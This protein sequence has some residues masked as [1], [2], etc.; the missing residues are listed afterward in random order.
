MS[1][2]PKEEVDEK[3]AKNSQ[4]NQKGEENDKNNEAYFLILIPSEEKIDFQGLSYKTKNMIDPSIIFKDRVEKDDKTYL[5]EIVFKFKKKK[6]KKEKAGNENESSKSTKYAITFFE[7][8]HIY[9]ITFAS[10]NDCFIY[11]P[12]LDIG[13]KFLQDIP[14]EPIQQNIV[15]LYIKL[16]IFIKALKKTKEINQKEE[17]LYED[18]IDLYEQK[19]Q[20]SLLI[21]LFLK[22]Y[23]KNKELCKQLI[24][25]FYRINDEENNDK[26]DDL[27]NHLKSF[28]DILSNARDI[29]DENNYNPIHFYG[30]LFCYLH[31]YDENNFPKKIEEFSEGNSKT[32]YEI[33]IHYYSHFINPLK[34]SQKFFKGFIGYA[35]KEN[36][37][38]KQFERI[39]NY[40]EDIETYLFI[41]DSNKKEIFKKYKELR[42]KP[43]EMD[44]SLKLL[45]HKDDKTKKTITNEKHNNESESSDEDNEKG[46]EYANNIEN[47]CHVII[48]L[49]ESIIKF[50]EE[51]KTLVIYMRSTFWI[52]LLDQ[53]KFPDWENISNCHNLRELYKK[54]TNLVN[55][56]Y[57]ENDIKNDVNTFFDRDQFAFMLNNLIKEFLDKNQ[58]S[59]TNAE[60]LGCVRNFNPY[61]SIADEKDKNK[62]KNNR[63]TY[64][65][66]YVNFSKITH[67]F[68]KAFHIFNFETMFEENISEYI[69]KITG[70]IK[71]IK[72]FGNIIKLI[73]EKRMKEDNQKDYYRIL[74]EKYRSVIKGNIKLIKD[75]KELKNGIK[76]IAE[77]V[78]K[79]FLFYGKND[80]LKDEIGSLED[81]IKSLIYLELIT[82]YNKEEYKDQKE[83]I[84]DIY[85][86][87]D[88]ISKKEGRDNIIKLVKNLKDNDRNIFIYEKL[89]KAC[90]FTTDEFFSNNEN[91]K[92]KTLCLL[93]E[94][95]NKESKD[96]KV[97]ELN[98]IEQGEKGNK[99]AKGLE[100]VLDKV[101]KEL[102][103]GRITKR[104]LERFLNIKKVYIN[105]TNETKKEKE[106]KNVSV[107]KNDESDKYAKEKLCLIALTLKDYVAENKYIEYKKIIDNINETIAKLITTKDSLMIFHRNKYID[108]IKKLAKILIEIEN[109]PIAYL[110]N[111]ETS[112]SVDD[113]INTH[114]DLCDQI[115]EVKDFLLFK[116]IFEDT[117][118]KDQEDRFSKAYNKL[119][120]LKI[121]FKE[122]PNNI[123]VIF[124]DKDFVNIFKEIKEELGRKDEIKS[125]EFLEQMKNNFDIT[126]ENAIK[127]LKML[128][129]SKKYEMIVKSIDYFFHYFLNKDLKLNEKKK[130]L[131][132]QPLIILKSELAELEKKDY[133]DYKSNSPYYRVFTSIYEKKEEIDFLLR[134]IKEAQEEPKTKN[135][136]NLKDRLQNNLD[137]T[138]RSITIKDIDDMIDCLK[139]VNKLL[140][141]DINGIIKY[142]KELHEEDIKKF[143]SFS[144]KFVSIIALDNKSGGDSF[145]EVYDIIQDA[146]VLFHLDSEDLRYK[147]NGEEKKIA[148]VDE[149]IKLGNKINIEEKEENKKKDIFELKCDKLRFFKDVVS[150]IE[151]IYDRIDILRSKGYNIPIEIKIEIKYPN[152]T[153][154]SDEKPITYELY[155]KPKDF[156][157][158]KDYLFEIKNEYET[159]LITNYESE[160]YIRFLYGKLLR[161]VSQHQKGH[162]Q[163]NEIIRYILN[164]TKV[165]K[166][167]NTIQDT[168]EK[169][170]PYIG[171][172]YEVDYKTY[173]ATIFKSIS[174][175]LID[176]FKVNKLDFQK[177]YENM[178]IKEEYKKFGLVENRLEDDDHQHRQY[179]K[180]GISIIKCK[181]EQS[182]E[183]NILS[184]FSNKLDKLPIA[185]NILICSRETTIEE[186]QSFL[187]RA[188]LCE[189]NT[190]FVLE[191]LDSFSNFQQNKM[192]SYIDKLTSIKM[193]KYKNKNKDN[194][195]KI[196]KN[197]DKSDSSDYL[198]SYIVFIFKKLSNESTF[199]NELNNYIKNDKEDEEELQPNYHDEENK[200]GDLDISNISFHSI[201]SIKNDDI[202]DIINNITV[203]SSDVCGLGKSFKIKKMIERD[204]RIKY[205]FP[206]G[207]KLTKNIIYKK[208]LDLFKK[209]KVN[210]YVKKDENSEDNDDKEEIN[211]EY[212][213]FD[214]VAIHLDIVETKEIDLVNEFLFSFLI[215][216]FYTNNEN[217]IYIPN[218]IKI[219]IEVPNSTVNYLKK[220]GIL[221]AFNRENIILGDTSQE[222]P[223]NG[224]NVKNVP[225][226]P[227]E[228]ESKIKEKFKRINKI[229]TNEE[230]EKFIKENFEK[231]HIKKYSYKQIQ[232]FINLYISQFDS[233]EGE[234]K[235]Y[236]TKNEDI[237]PDC[238]N[239]F[240]ESTKYFIDSGFTNK[241]MNKN[242]VKDIF[243]LCEGAYKSNDSDISKEKFNTPLIYIN[244][245]TKTCE[246]EKLPDIAKEK[247]KLISNKDVDIVYLI[248]A[249]GSMGHE[250]R[251]AKENV[252]KI[253]DKLTESNKGYN[254]RFG[255]VFYRDKIDVPSDKDEYFQFTDNMKDLQ[256]KIGKVKAKG[257]GDTP[258]DW[259]GGYEIA[260]NNMKWREDGIKLIIHIADAG[261]HGKRFTIKD[262]KHNDQ[263]KLL[264]PKIEECVRRNINIIG[265]KISNE[266]IQSF[267]EI[268]KIYNNFKKDNYKYDNGQFIEIYE[269]FRDE[270]NQEVVSGN[271]NRLVMK[272]AEN[273]INP[274]YKYLKRLK[275]ILDL[276]NDVE[277]EKGDKKSLISLLNDNYVITED[278]YKKMVLLY[279]RIKANVP[280]IIMGETGCGK[281]S[282]I[283]KLS[284]ILNNGKKLVEIINIHPGTTDE[285]I[286]KEMEK[287][288][289]IAKSEDYKKKELWIFFD[290]INT[291]L[292]LSLLTEIFVNRTFN[293]KKLEDN[294]RL[295]GACNPYRKREED[296]EICGLIRE[297]DEDDED[298][299]DDQSK[300]LVYIVEQLPESLLYYVFSFGSISEVDEKKYIGSII[301]K[302]FTKEEEKLHRQTTEAIS[303]SHI[304]LRK[305]FK[306]PSI[307]SLREIARFTSCVEFFQEYFPT[308][309]NENRY[310][311]DDEIKKLY[312]I[313]SIICSI[314]ICYYTRLTNETKRKDYENFLQPTLLNIVNGE[315]NKDE[316]S[317]G[318][319]LDKIRYKKLKDDLQDLKGKSFENFSVLLKRE[320]EFLIEQVEP[321]KG[322]GE[323]QSLKENLFL[324]FLGVV[325]KIPLI[326]V[327]KPGTGKSL[328][329]QLIYNSMRGEYSKKP[330]FKNYPK[331]DQTYFQGSKNTN[332]EDVEELFKKTEELSNVYKA[333]KD[334]SI[335]MILF[336]ELGLAEQSKTKPLKVLHSKLEYDGKKD[337]TCFI[338]ISNYSLDAAKVNRALS[339]SV[340]N[341]EDKLDQLKMTAESIVKSIISDDIYNNN[342]IFN[343]LS[344]AYNR[345][346]YWLNFIKELTVL[347]QYFADNKKIE[348]KDFGEIKRD[349]EFIKLLKKDRKIKTE[350]HGNRDF[351]SLIKGV[352]IEVSKLSN[353]SDE[354]VIVP[355][356]NEFIER[357][358]GGIT[359]DIDIDFNLIFD[360]I[361]GDMNILKEILKEKLE[362]KSNENKNEYDEEGKKKE[363]KNEKAKN[364]IKVTSVFLFKKI[365]NEACSLE[366]QEGQSYQI[367]KDDLIKYDLNKCINNNINDNNSRYLLLE[368]RSNL[369]PLINRIIRVQNSDRKGNVDTLIGS[370]FS[371]DNN[372]DYKAKKINEI[373][374]CAS[375]KYKL[376]ILQDL[377]Q[378]LPYLYDLFNMNYKLIDDQKF[379]RICLENFSE[380][381]TPVSESFKII[382]L[383]DKKFVKKLDM[384]FLNRLEK[385]QISFQDLLDKDKEENQ[386]ITKLIENI[387]REIK[388]KEEIEKKKSTFNYDLKSLL[389]NCN[390]QE[391][392]GLVY[393]LYFKYANERSDNINEDVI[394]ETVYTKVSNLLPQD[395]AVILP[396]K[397]PIKE[398]YF[399]KKK[400]YNFIKYKNDLDSNVQD[401]INYK[402]SI[403]YTFSDISGN[404][405]DFN[406]DNIIMIENISTEGNLKNQIDEIKNRNKNKNIH[407][408]YIL[409]QFEDNN[410]K[411]IQFTSDY[412][413]NYLEDDYH[414]IFIIYIHRNMNSDSERVQRIYSIPNIY[415]NINQLFIDNLE[416]P[417]I[418]L[419][420]L[421]NKDVKEIM[422]SFNNLD[423]EFR[424]ALTNFVY[425][426]LNSKLNQ[427]SKKTDI[428]TYLTE[429]YPINRNE[430]F[431]ENLINYMMYNDIGFKNK[432]IEK[433]KELIITDKDALKDCKNLIEKILSDCYMNKDK[434]DIVSILLDYIK[435]NVFMKYLNFIFNVLE[436][437]NFLTTLIELSD[438]KTCR[439]GKN[440]EDKNTKIIKNLETTFLKEIKV[441]NKKYEPK[442][443]SNYRIPGFYNFY[444]KLSEVLSKDINVE[445][446]DNEN[447]LREPEDISNI[448]KVKRDFHEKEEELLN[449]VLKMIKQDKLYWDLV[450]EINPDLILN[451]YI[452]FYLEK[453]L[454]IYSKP[455]IYL[456][457][458][459]L[460]NRFSDDTNIIKN[461]E[462]K[463]INKVII[464]II[465]L[466]SYI[467]YIKDIATLFDFGKTIINDME[468]EDF[469]NMIFNSISDNS[470]KFIVNK[471]RVEYT[472][473]INECFYKVLAGICLSVSTNNIDEMRISIESYCG[474]LKEVKKIIQ[475]MDEHF[476]LNIDELYI[477]DELIKIIEYNP[478]TSKKII[479]QIRDKLVENAKIIQKNLSK[480]KLAENFKGLNDLLQKIKNEQTK[481]KYYATLKYIYK[482]EIEKVNDKVYCIVILKEIIKQK[483]IL[484]ISNDI[485]RYLL[486]KFEDMECFDSTKDY[487]L[488]TKDNIIKFL[489][490]KL[491]L[492]NNSK[493]YYIAL[494]E[495]I[496]YFFERISLLYLKGFSK[497]K[498]SFIEEKENEGHIYVFKECN[499][500][501]S[502]LNKDEINEGFN[503]NITKL[504]CIAYIKTFCYMF[505]KMHKK[506]KFKPEN[507]IEI[508]N[509]SDEINMVKLYIYKIIYNK[510]K[511]QI[512]TFVDSDIIDKYKL[513]TYK[514]FEDFIKSED[515]EKLE[516][517]SYGDNKSNDIFKILEENSKNQFEDK[518][519]DD[520]ISKPR[521]N[522]DDFYRAAYQFIL[523]KLNDEDFEDD[524][525]YTNFYE[526]V[527]KPLYLNEDYDE[528]ENKL[529][530]LMKIF[531]E[532]ETYLKFKEKYEIKPEDIE[533]L[534]Y[535]YRYC[536]NEVKSLKNRDED[537]IYSYLYN[538]D[539]LD[540]FDKKFYPGNDNNKNEPYYELYSRIVKQLQENP[541]DG[542]YVCL[543][544]KGYCHS[545]SGG[546]VGINEINMVCP[547]C[548]R[549]IGSK[550]FYTKERDKKD[551]NKKIIIKVYKMVTSN[552]NYYRIFKDSEQIDDL[553]RNKEHYEKFENMKYM[554]VEEFKKKYIEPLYKKEKGL[555]KIDMNTF[556]KENKVIRNLSKISYRLL[557]YILYCNLFFAYLYTKEEK[558]NDYLPEGMTWITMIKECFNK[559]KIN[560][561]NKGIKHLEIFMNCIFKDLFAKLHNKNCIN[562]FESLVKFEDELEDLINKKCEE[563]KKEIEKYK[564]D[565]KKIIGDEKSGIA[566]IKE[567][568]GKSKYDN[569]KE[570]PFYEYFYYTDYL[571]E[572]YIK[573]KLKEKDEN[574]YPVLNSYLKNKKQENE[575][576]YSLDHLNNFNKVLKLFNDIYSNQ[577]TRD[578]AEKKIINTSK[579]YADEKNAKLIDDF[580]ELYN[581]FD[582]QDDE[583]NNLELDKEKNTIIDFLLIDDNKYGKSYKKI[584]KEFINRQNKSLESLLNEKISTGIFNSKSKN[585]IS[586]QKIKDSEIFNSE[587]IDETFTNAIFNSSYRKYINT[588]KPENY[589]EYEIRM[590][591]IESEM[592]DSILKD[593]KLLNYDIMGFNFDNEVFTYG[594]GDLISTFAYKKIPINDDDKAVIYNFIIIKF[595]G[596][597]DIYKIIINNFI[598]LIEYLNR[599]SKDK[600]NNNKI[601]GSTKI[602][603]I[604]KN[605]KNIRKEFSEIFQEKEQNKKQDKK[606]VKGKT[607]VKN[608]NNEM[609]NLFGDAVFN[610][611]KITNIFA[612]F[613]EL[614]FKYVKKDIAKYQEENKEEK[615]V[616]NFDDKDMIIK[617]SD[618][619]SAIRLFITLV[620][621]REEEK[622]KEEKIK[623]NK[624][625]IIDYLKNKDLW[626]STFYDSETN[627]LKFEGDLSKLK[628]LNI[629]IKEILY[630]YNYLIGNND[631]GFEEEVKAYIREKEEAAKKERETIRKIEDEGTRRKKKFQG[632][633]SEDSDESDDSEDDD[634]DSIKK[635][636]VKKGGKNTVKGGKV[637]QSNNVK[638]HKD[639]DD[640]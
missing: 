446:L 206:L 210:T 570:F 186:M 33:L 232:T 170:S 368:I 535:G 430:I 247:D 363:E 367:K 331:I 299:K 568:Y 40:I 614:I 354:D 85:L 343:I 579:I 499:K 264:P 393:Y 130:K 471:K 176:L 229:G 36:K 492:E 159:Q 352:A 49:S 621:Y 541:D 516:N 308:K 157:N 623:S 493:D 557:N 41:I 187:Y 566:L 333:R 273:V 589:N 167:Q 226:L 90:Q 50:S 573:K 366:K 19:K 270:K 612:Y 394:K 501:L 132:E 451:D 284:Q 301:Q 391:I 114:K 127:D 445:F 194:K 537:Y 369:N 75:D 57:E 332:P 616:Y 489:D 419:N 421:L 562:N 109:S 73:D 454:G 224:S 80:F 168:D 522:F 47:E 488:E 207:G 252:I 152:V 260:L 529:I 602:C 387:D 8:E 628:D 356:I 596:N 439:L 373:Q 220:F 62:F 330:F 26:I 65:F 610:V 567:I 122:N 274:S 305:S 484:K 177:H 309:K 420:D 280:V 141:K 360:D 396:E 600:N 140:N 77:F 542:C 397:H 92:I 51:E 212:R 317:E 277:N 181:E 561:K 112:K 417:E 235:F 21:S 166:E 469:Y 202:D 52:N 191:I 30:I 292:S 627:K 609:D 495:I 372:S 244:K 381:L 558:F 298:D 345:Y 491:E 256:E 349:D 295:I 262:E 136:K 569:S 626:K 554:T 543:C 83:F 213:E 162:C 582:L 323:N 560:L 106:P 581:S 32:L 475:Q 223:N 78:S 241:I 158:I 131:S 17:K 61:F 587:N 221:N 358:F 20:F 586:V 117:K 392:G 124:N 320:E 414:Y 507:I 443:L 39:M 415:E 300:K 253:F 605:L 428:S 113:L 480:E 527:C 453:S 128:I 14:P 606:N 338:G 599:A 325:T 408:P 457:K 539:K 54:Y 538:K 287:M 15:P 423:K 520:K 576:K 290:E 456:I 383:V 344:R 121:K 248:D 411:K 149:L 548:N 156:N 478:N 503:V 617:K 107:P 630:F 339:L 505:I 259:V 511:K 440:K 401:L 251:A 58:Q 236:N 640:D 306:D 53:Y 434:I 578:E 361:K 182:M 233:F 472:K 580:I 432:I 165:N 275:K 474:I 310:R 438:E 316:K 405:K 500:F 293:G 442:F 494:S 455:F 603:D 467:T 138:N 261:A 169:H 55:K 268:S 289:E 37:E 465:W 479:K 588:Q 184:L 517:L 173:M 60:K 404:I 335:C 482:K 307:V 160:K 327:G 218:N 486:I 9:N 84:Y 509:E 545:V 359:Y 544:D 29:L 598:T 81:N 279:Y 431:I 637:K 201:R 410:S 282:L 357:N 519:T 315:K 399:K 534:L 608:K 448:N 72:T 385:M 631:E 216:K 101:Q 263:G 66:D 429:R 490:Q 618:L 303:K 390:E 575:D 328:S 87:K 2:D 214:K 31:F 464:K 463:P 597:N 125:D 342:L 584:Y 211:E 402:I 70:K 321:D 571:N 625:N 155:G 67:A 288:N 46:L 255:S 398:K 146:R 10:K 477:M 175:Y 611:S 497:K 407:Y 531:F 97:N 147:I 281:T 119:K 196:Y 318:N 38:Q 622:D 254:F 291:C 25:I 546:F 552:K 459:L 521:T 518:I 188:I 607:N 267:D 370:P 34:Q 365:Y 435:E 215:T 150:K 319:L 353:K 638:K 528:E 433:A 163:I 555:N 441:D 148:N 246:F 222:K 200:M 139:H 93:K 362:K 76:I 192:Y 351:Y 485:F 462:K 374:N 145:K 56:L 378:I 96:K 296:S 382:V 620:L 45:K 203:I 225:M 593:K 633:E 142:L 100:S 604:N 116:K 553:K 59:L 512:N 240:A 530:S 249:T 205:H 504:F 334:K 636:N 48:K 506:N 118:G 540:D 406:D 237:T 524:N 108:D 427:S 234:L 190:L 120:E 449:K 16:N 189:F 302:L 68:N 326:I 635:K 473:K 230:I 129:K 257:G 395:I 266:P 88:N 23:G 550:E 28:N 250:I 174:D 161:K 105:V 594:I 502:E 533:A 294:I 515:I 242:N 71:D 590:E 379:V 498:E 386:S 436:D 153:N 350:F 437:N 297:D 135:L 595:A 384:A 388:L 525:S 69:N 591:Q 592:T 452:I 412:I 164:K 180:K 418:S 283:I 227:L 228:L 5:E 458:L 312:K 126:D 577:I 364:K 526:N 1:Q 615:M 209:I 137:P 376:I 86:K 551:E 217:I 532:K 4:E 269:F 346:K 563:A 278:N 304:F 231:I 104:D 123:E 444:K 461:N 98:I 43:F 239:L 286:T 27:K 466:E 178:K 601:N 313:K 523:S 355:K 183:E 513:K 197:I 556:R 324:I 199:K 219:Y 13:N 110:R 574:D 549:E 426:K 208:I 115:K 447:Y 272:A 258:E 6:K 496:I 336:D 24:E 481:E 450:N 348:G 193:E 245:E 314:Y 416:G 564:E 243:D 337:G 632:G 82:S 613:L 422:S 468:G 483:E 508:I 42:S 64:I 154:E 583:G 134:K 143:E 536:L 7:E 413:I 400:Y 585:R 89:L 18:T 22:I 341:L 371:D 63:E 95:L 639:D 11:Q 144:K 204:N 624:K 403:I 111:N 375:Q 322:I 547:K 151:I 91:Y 572:D 172:N 79:I 195:S 102:D 619:A 276:D 133:Y 565:E 285:D 12:K 179:K 470:I 380:Q 94:E 424:E 99:F 487:L 44:A 329:A 3:E 74:K 629:K 238:I 171:E 425:D 389:V 347:K 514:G 510:N 634:D 103:H 311:L 460:D 476:G 35:L 185:Q 198:D 340:P 377:D 271:F 265:F 559:L 409:I